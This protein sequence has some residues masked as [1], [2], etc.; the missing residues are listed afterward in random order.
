MRL[1]RPYSKGR[2]VLD[3]QTGR[4]TGQQR[5]AQTSAASRFRGLA[6]EPRAYSPDMLRLDGEPTG[7]DHPLAVKLHE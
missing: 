7:P 2:L 6:G 4:S 5:T 3:L 1:C